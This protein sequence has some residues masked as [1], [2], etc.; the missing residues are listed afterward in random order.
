MWAKQ[1]YRHIPRNLTKGDVGK[2]NK[3]KNIEYSNVVP[4]R[5]SPTEWS[6]PHLVDA[7]ADLDA[8][9]AIWQE[10]V[11]AKAKKEQHHM[12]YDIEHMIGMD[13]TYESCHVGETPWIVTIRN[14]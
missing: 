6:K 1:V 5:S 3:K 4:L 7:K 13:P 9:P 2:G 10:E 14:A 8:S 12:I 11:W